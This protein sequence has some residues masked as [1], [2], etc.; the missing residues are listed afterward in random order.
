MTGGPDHGPSNGTLGEIVPAAPDAAASPAESL[1]VPSVVRH[2]RF[3]RFQAWMQTYGYL[4]AGS[5][6]LITGSMFMLSGQIIANRL[7]SSQQFSGVSFAPESGAPNYKQDAGGSSVAVHFEGGVQGTAQTVIIAFSRMLPGLSDKILDDVRRDDVPRQLGGVFRL[8]EDALAAVS[9]PVLSGNVLNQLLQ[10]A[11]PPGGVPTRNAVVAGSPTPGLASTPA[12]TATPAVASLASSTPTATPTSTA[13]PTQQSSFDGGDERTGTPTPFGFQSPTPPLPPT[14]VVLVPT[15]IIPEEATPLAP[16]VVPTALP[17]N[18]A[19][20]TEIPV[21][22]AVPPTVAPAPTVAVPTPVPPPTVAPPTAVPTVVPTVEE[23]PPT[24]IPPTPTLTPTLTPTP[25]QTPSGPS[26]TP[27]I[28]VLLDL[29]LP[30]SGNGYS[31]IF[32]GNVVLNPGNVSERTLNVQNNG[33]LP[34]TY[35]LTTNG[36]SGILWTDLVNGLH[37]EITRDS[38]VVY[39]GPLQATNVTLGTLAKGEQDVIIITVYLP[40][41][42]GSQFQGLNVSVNFDFTAVGG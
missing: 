35:S 3:A 39:N 34:F 5:I 42:A 10:G 9:A 7:N 19:I 41:T 20:A 6:A 1:A 26:P 38:N 32:S 40:S 17:E 37:M 22:T 23:I 24:A 12:S 18:T 31:A 25:T 21:P 14:P 27:T 29:S 4:L 8:S 36:G 30:Q 11:I 16:V 33:A 2:V 13:T 28:P 15:P